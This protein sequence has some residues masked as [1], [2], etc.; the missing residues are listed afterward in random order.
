[1]KPIHTVTGRTTTYRI[2]NDAGCV[3]YDYKTGDGEYRYYIR[4]HLGNVRVEIDGDGNVVRAA[5]YTVSGIPIEKS[6]LAYPGP[7]CYAGLAYYDELGNGWYDNNARLMESLMMRFTAMDPLCEK[8][9]A[10]SPYAN[11]LCNPL[12]FSDPDGRAV[13]P[14]GTAELI[15]IQNTLPK[16]ERKY[17]QLDDMGFINKSLINS[18]ISKSDNYNDL[19]QMVNDQKFVINATLTNEYIYMDNQGNLHKS[20]M[21]YGE[22][23]PYFADPEFKNASGIT[24]GETGK[25][26][27][28]L[29]PGKGESGV[30]SASKDEIN[31]YI[32]AKLS[33]VGMAET[34]SHEGYGHTIMYLNT[35]DR[36]KSGH[37][38]KGNRDMNIDLLN[39]IIKSRKETIQNMIGE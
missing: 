23:D 13:R 37:I 36:T 27:V 16:E 39:R 38:I 4:D 19:V 22:A 30:N 1:M 33:T 2:Y 35:L 26:G 24:T 12:R 7:E 17:V 8:Y 34:F 6:W 20:Q 21:G 31:I 15:M 11:C 25:L 10:I 5:D 32:N 3:L 18:H 29:L 14:A 9:P 28:T